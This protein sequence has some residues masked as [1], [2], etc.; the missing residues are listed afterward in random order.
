MPPGLNTARLYN[1][2]LN[3]GLANKDNPLYQVI[4]SLIGALV[5]LEK[6]AGGGGSPGDFNQITIN[7]TVIEL[8]GGP[9]FDGIDGM[10]GFPGIQG[11]QGI[12]GPAGSGGSGSGSVLQLIETIQ[13]EEHLFALRPALLADFRCSVY[14]TAFQS[15]NSG[16]F[17][18]LTFDAEDFDTSVM[19]DN[20]TNNTRI[21]IP[22]GGDGYYLM[23]GGI[24]F[25]NHATGQRVAIPR[26]NGTT[27]MPGG[28][29]FPV[30]S[31]LSTSNALI[32]VVWYYVAGEYVELMGFQ[33]S[34]VALN[35]GSIVTGVSNRFAANFLQMNRLNYQ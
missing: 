5:A 33:D 34:G 20:V 8:L 23:T 16:V 4:Y 35:L 31:A 22:P 7:R 12:Q 28:M 27:F 9:A 26:R 3:T 18:A 2:L 17:T 30:N 1:Q 29:R 10:D 14:G 32:S 15:V 25:E 19:H 6:T 11:P 24:Q 13:N 21:T